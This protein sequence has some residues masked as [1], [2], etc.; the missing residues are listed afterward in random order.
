MNGV[1]SQGRSSA[2]TNIPTSRSLVGIFSEVS[3][4]LTSSP[5]PSAE[6]PR[7]KNSAAQGAVKQKTAKKSGFLQLNAETLV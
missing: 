1:S 5:V 6:L 4:V 7:V 2:L 3:M